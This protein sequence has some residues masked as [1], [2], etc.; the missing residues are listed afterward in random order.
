[1]PDKETL[2]RDTPLLQVSEE[3][4]NIRCGPYYLL[5]VDGYPLLRI[6]FQQLLS[7]ALVV[8]YIFLK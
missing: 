1:M 5:V 2:R 3:L 8:T 7:V 6:L 4:L